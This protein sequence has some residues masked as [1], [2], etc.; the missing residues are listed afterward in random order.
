MV[1]DSAKFSFGMNAS[2][3]ARKNADKHSRKDL[4]PQPEDTAPAPSEEQNPL[5]KMLMD[6]SES[7]ESLLEYYLF[8]TNR[9]NIHRCSDNC[10][11]I[12]KRSAN[13]GQNVC[14]M[15]LDQKTISERC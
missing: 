4:W 3:P 12:P 5:V 13:Q 11:V 15:E 2:H 6:V 14:M 7:Q 10:W 8:L 9:I 1:S